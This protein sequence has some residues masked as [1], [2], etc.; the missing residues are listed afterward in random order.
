MSIGKS[1]GFGNKATEVGEM[2]TCK[3]EHT[4][5]QSVRSA[6]AAA[7][8]TWAPSVTVDRSSRGNLQELCPVTTVSPATRQ[9][10]SRASRA[11]D[12]AG[13]RP[14]LT[15]ATVPRSRELLH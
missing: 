3:N 11:G 13:R 10:S 4:N 8:R 12:C 7:W 14:L 5:C 1:I 15:M 2:L 9:S 6:C